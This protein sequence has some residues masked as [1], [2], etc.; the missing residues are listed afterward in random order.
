[1]T[2]I[3]IKRLEKLAAFLDKLPRKKF[4]FSILVAERDEDGCGTICC[5]IGWIPAVFPKLITW[6]EMRTLTITKVTWFLFG[7]FNGE[8]TYRLFFPRSSTNR[9]SALPPSATPKQVA[10]EIRKFICEKL[11]QKKGAK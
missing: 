3:H 9:A 5:A 1:M 4:D 7:I 8:D 10:R 6:R 11:A 2:K